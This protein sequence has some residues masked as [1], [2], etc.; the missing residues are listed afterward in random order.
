MKARQVGR[1]YRGPLFPPYPPEGWLWWLGSEHTYMLRP[2]W[3]KC[4]RAN[5]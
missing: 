1:L 5:W 4:D 3:R 2:Y